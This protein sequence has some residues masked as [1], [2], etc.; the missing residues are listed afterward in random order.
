MPT[1]VLFLPQDPIVGECHVLRGGIPALQLVALDN[2]RA[3][4]GPMVRLPA[5]A[6][7]MPCGEGF[8]DQT[9]RVRFG[10]SFYV[11]FQKDLDS[12]KEAIEITSS[13]IPQRKAA[14]SS[15]SAPRRRYQSAT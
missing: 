3:R 13:P 1:D 5:G 11:V 4:W 2:G 8:D 15:S 6:E 10:D 7:L 14:R 9:L 12:S